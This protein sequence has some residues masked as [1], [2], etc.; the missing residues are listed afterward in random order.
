MEESSDSDHVNVPGVVIDY[1]PSETKRYI[2]SPSIAVLPNGDYIA[3]HDFFGPGSTEKRIGETPIFRSEDAGQTWGRLTDLE[4]QF[5]SSLFVHNQSLFIMGTSCEYG[6]VVIRKSTDGGE[7]WTTPAD[8][9]TGLLAADGRYHTAPVPVVVHE[10]R[11]WRAMEYADGPR[12]NWPAFVMSA[13][14]DEDLLK[15]ENWTRS[16]FLYHHNPPQRWLEGNIVI[17]P[18]N[19][20]VN[21]LRL[22][23]LGPGKAAV[24]HVSDDGKTVSFDPEVDIIDFIGGGTKFT[25]RYDEVPQRYWSLANKQKDPP[26]YRNI[27]ALTSSPDLRNWRVKSIILRHEDKENHA[28][29]YVDWRFEADDIIVVSRTAWD[30]SHK[31]HDANYMTFHRIH[32]FRELTS[33]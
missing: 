29:Q 22:N 14:V 23:G 25:I 33:S 26:A 8:E 27:L 20:R 7:T 9:N 1:S 15:A 16:N 24:V 11:I 32:N 17:T 5:W 6:F 4:G 28:F 13:P 19:R 18:E 30:E 21:I 10:G 2:G 12:P 3:S 31:A